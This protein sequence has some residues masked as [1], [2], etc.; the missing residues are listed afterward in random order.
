MMRKGMRHVRRRVCTQV[1]RLVRR[2]IAAAR[3]GL[4]GLY[5]LRAPWEHPSRV[6][7]PNDGTELGML[8]WLLEVGQAAKRDQVVL[9]VETNETTQEVECIVSGILK[10]VS[11]ITYLRRTA[12]MGVLAVAA[13]SLSA[14]SIAADGEPQR[15][16]IVPHTHW[17]GAVFKTREEYLDIGLP[18]IEKA[19]YLLKK[20]PEYRFV[21]DQAC[22][23]APFLERYPSEVAE[24]RGFLAQGRLQIAGGT[25]SMHD[26]NMPSGESIA[27]QFL[28]GKTFFRESLGYDVTSGWA[29]DT[30][31]HNAQMPQILK[32]AGMKS[33][34]FM[35]GAPQPNTPSEFLWHG[36]DGSKIPA[37]WLPLGY[38]PLYTVPGSEREFGQV[39]RSKFD[40]L[41]PSGKRADRVLL[42]G[43]DVS[44]PSEALPALV[45]QYN[46]AGPNIEAQFATP[47]DFETVVARR[48]DQPTLQGELNPVGQGIY[49]SR[50][51]LK[52]G[53]RQVETLLAT[54]ERLTVIASVAGATAPPADL[55][56]A[57]EALL[58]NE[59]HDPM[60]GSVVDKVY[61]EELQD[62]AGARRIAEKEISRS[63]DSLL[64]HVDSAGQGVPV[65]VFN[66]LGWPRTDI[67]EVDIPFSEPAIHAIS[68]LDPDG[69]AVPIQFLD[70]RRNA[71]GGMYQAHIAFIAH[72][73]PG[74]GL[75]VYH[76]VANALGSQA[77][78]AANEEIFSQR[79][80]SPWRDH[81]SIDNDFYRVSFDFKTGAITSLILKENGWEALA[82]PANVVAREYDGGDFWELYGPLTGGF[83]STHREV[84]VPRPQLTL[85]SSDNLGIGV[86]STGPVFSEFRAQG[87]N[88]VDSERPFGKNKFA[89]RVRVYEDLHRID[90]RTDLTNQEELVRYRAVF[91][92]TIL[93]GVATEEIPFGAID[94]P[95][96]SEFPAQNW[97][98][99]GNGKRGVALINRGIPGNNVA[100]GKLMLSLMRSTRLLGYPFP[101][102]GEP[103]TGSNT[104]L[105]VGDRYT[106]D[107]AIVP[108]T[109][110]WRSAVLWRAGME[111]NNP[112][113]VRTA[114]QHSG[115]LPRRWGLLS[116]SADN[117]VVSAL[118][119]GKGRTVILRV[120]EAAGRATPA[121]R[122][123]FRTGIDR[124][125]ETN[126][127]EDP[128]EEIPH[129]TDG[130]IFDLRPFQIR[131][132]QLTLKDRSPMPS[133]MAHR[134]GT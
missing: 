91:P 53:M 119:P 38:G 11:R 23:V 120:Y 112:L 130:F 15:A 5:A 32:L 79:S 20:Y 122:A 47:A 117:V 125:R 41:A 73:V 13:T 8:G 68:L 98:D 44:E 111:F 72:D 114:A 7:A 100:D 35:R 25:Y 3:V 134:S 30:F 22:Y 83:V 81:G 88:P 74:L 66:V 56:P 43:S 33:Y 96:R 28:I 63:S 78:P 61:T 24:F 101:G 57:W 108:H 37:F 17:E 121:V 27:R 131:T 85:W 126:L 64:E 9:Q 55:Q 89:T 2:K 133:A 129:S 124:V 75:A 86:A 84:T 31:G 4:P 58:F 115:G 76:A 123:S 19:L 70:V 18:N 40:S 14:V 116:L 80:G 39:L 92:T 102:E 36:L 10:A 109:G 6:A 16:F 62:Y 69:K 59:E 90:I 21:L 87:M 42:A 106:L 12:A 1:T 104:G 49:S 67:A 118:K 128:G 110:D 46:G 51:E 105:G 48:T 45:A 34:W 82:G 29:I 52:Q 54:A 26:N 60:A 65:V 113:L 99:Y 95:Q 132:F 97:I 77:P 107:Y 50:I 93:N 94:R 103:G 71:D 127:I